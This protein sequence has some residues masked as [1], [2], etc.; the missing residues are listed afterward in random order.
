MI[1]EVE[2]QVV[3]TQIQE[4]IRQVPVPQVQAVE[5]IVEVPQIQTVERIVEVPQM[6]QQ[7][8]MTQTIA[9]PQMTYGAPIATGSIGGYGGFGTAT[10]AA[11]TTTLVGGGLVAPTTVL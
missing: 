8:V 7:Q 11:P 3:V 6:M 1:Q 10:M 2:R 5:K 9:A 4:V